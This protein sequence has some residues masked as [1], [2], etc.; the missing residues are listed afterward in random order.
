[1]NRP[2]E[3]IITDLDSFDAIRDGWPRLAGLLTELKAN[4]H[5]TWA[6][7]PLFRL[8]E[9]HPAITSGV[10][11]TV[12]HLLESFPGFEVHLVES[13]QRRPSVFGVMMVNRLLNSG[14]STVGIDSL[15]P[16][17][18]SLPANPRCQ[19]AVKHEI[20]GVLAGRQ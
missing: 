3:E 10:F 11:M 14:I 2:I 18:E 5:P 9:R 4:P 1:M 7:D 16:L 20:E 8:F 19:R 13:L 12:L 15:L 17:L 6:M